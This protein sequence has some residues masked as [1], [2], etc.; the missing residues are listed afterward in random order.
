MKITLLTGKT[1][2]L[3]TAFDFPLN[4][5]SSFKIRRLTLRIDAKKRVAVLNMPKLCSKKKAYEFIYVHRDW[6]EANLAKLSPV[7]EFANGEVLEI[8]GK[9]VV[10]SY[11]AGSL[12]AVKEEA[13]VLYVGGE[14]EFLHRRIKDYIKRQAKNEFLKRSRCLAEQIG[15]S[16][17]NVAVKDTKSRWGS[18]SSLNNINYNW[19][20]A[21]APDYVIEY[22][23]AHEVSHLKHRDH[24]VSFWNCVKKLCPKASVGKIWLKEHGNELNV[25]R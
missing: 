19:R 6:I 18:C 24:S 13:G 16:V 21:L 22:L 1:Y 9:K 23:I 5:I 8:F 2:D 3:E 11:Q 12:S 17:E 7:R 15:C 14:L 25:W 4:V 20:V 10:I